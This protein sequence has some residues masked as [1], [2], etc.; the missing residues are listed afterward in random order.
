MCFQKINVPVRK[1]L[2]WFD[3]GLELHIEHQFSI[4]HE[5]DLAKIATPVSDDKVKEALPPRLAA[6]EN[7]KEISRSLFLSRSVVD[8]I[9]KRI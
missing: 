4:K 3:D 2:D 6:L 5:K 7:R 1:I 8:L 9:S